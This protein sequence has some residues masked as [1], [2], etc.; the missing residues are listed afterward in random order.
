MEKV[1]YTVE[2]ILRFLGKNA[3]AVRQFK[4]EGCENHFF[5]LDDLK[6]KLDR[7]QIICIEM[8]VDPIVVRNPKGFQ[9]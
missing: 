5:L 3:L 7:V 1:F 9:F 8:N 4:I 2:S 6:E